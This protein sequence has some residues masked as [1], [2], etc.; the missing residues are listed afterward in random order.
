MT[1][2]CKRIVPLYEAQ[3]AAPLAAGSPTAGCLDG[4]TILRFAHA[5][6][7]GGGVERHLADLNRELSLHHRLKTVQMHLTTDASHVAETEE[8]WGDSSLLHVPLLVGHNPALA[9]KRPPN[10]KV[11]AI[12]RLQ[13]VVLNSILRTHALNSLFAR[14][15]LRFRKLPLRK[16]EPNGAGTKAVELLKRFPIDLV[17]LH[18]SGGPD[19]VEVTR[20]AHAVGVP[21]ALIHHFSN[22]HLAGV[23]AR[24]LADSMAAI[25]GA[26][27]V[28]VP[29]YLKKDF[30]NLSDA[31]DLDFYR[32][33]KA[34]PVGFSAPTPVLYAPGR[35]TPEKGQM[36]VL[37]VAS[38][39]RRRGLPT[40]VV[41]AGRMDSPAFEKSLRDAVK[42][43]GLSNTVEFIGEL[44]LEQYRDWFGIA[45]IMLMPTHHHEGMP[46]TLIDSQAMKV[47][48]LVYD[49]GGTREGLRHG[50]TGF[51]IRP[52]DI[53]GMADAAE[54]ILRDQE[55][56]RRMSEMGR[57][58][59]EA[60]F[61]LQA[62]AARHEKFY[63][64]ALG[65]LIPERS[66][67]G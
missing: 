32:T 53:G 36:D 45:R 30:W 19:A 34:R 13:V 1:K 26:S 11:Q 27:K 24:R 59:V 40:T 57:S 31:V 16:G 62:F 64:K 39:L 28:G 44:T 9:A 66:P 52:G 49:S 5:F 8:I 12:K 38:L 37:K 7:T 29:L 61:S 17:V 41:F 14:T 2:V 21:V 35:L 25:G 15:L 10:K 42:Q 56:H 22:R 58:F 6:Q 65:H 3:I 55:M 50:E 43:E 54:L 33:V 47:P 46:R 60:H 67:A 18:T 4:L 48:P 51:L 20:A 23:A 63:L